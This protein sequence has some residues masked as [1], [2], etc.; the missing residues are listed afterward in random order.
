MNLEELTKKTKEHLD[1]IHKESEVLKKEIDA[2]LNKYLTKYVEQ[3]VSFRDGISIM[4][5]AQL[6]SFFDMLQTMSITKVDNE[7]KSPEV[8]LKDKNVLL[9]SALNGFFKAY[10]YELV[11]VFKERPNI[12]NV[13]NIKDTLQ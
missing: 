4:S 1:K 7:Q 8:I 13:T 10:N 2:I 12:E 3:K 5:T 9:L 6:K 11:C